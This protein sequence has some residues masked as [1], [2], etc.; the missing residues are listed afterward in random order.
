MPYSSLIPS[1]KA[2]GRGCLPAGLS[3]G[4]EEQQH[5]LGPLVSFLGDK[6]GL[7]LLFP[8]ALGCF[9]CTDPCVGT[10]RNG[11]GVEMF[12]ECSCTSSPGGGTVPHPPL[13]GA[14][15][16]G[17][18]SH[19][20]KLLSHLPPSPGLCQLSSSGLKPGLK[21][22]LKSGLIL[23]SP[24]ARARWWD[25]QCTREKGSGTRGPASSRLSSNSQSCL[26]LTRRINYC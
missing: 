13:R 25:L 11:R 24:S 8:S 26:F 1:L 22:G 20:G 7:P 3:R 14:G 12:Q 10:G 6:A 4:A 16:P 5:P 21:P 2:L 23:G 17:P 15:A 18:L 19:S 9:P